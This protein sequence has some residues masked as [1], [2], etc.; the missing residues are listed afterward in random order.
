MQSKKDETKKK[1]ERIST[2]SRIL[3]SGDMIEL[4]FDPL[5]GTTKFAVSVGGDISIVTE[6]RTEAGEFLVPVRGSHGLI[7][8]RVVL[9]PSLA[10]EY[11]SR[12]EL[13]EEVTAYIKRYVNLSPTF[14]TL[15]VHY[16]LLTWVYDVFAEVPYLRF[17]GDFGSGKTRALQVIGAITYK[18]IFASG[19]STVS[20]IFHSLDLFKGTLIF[21][22]ADFRFS[23]ER[24]EVTKI[25][26][27]GTTRGFPVLRASLSEKKDFDPKA[28]D[29]FGPKIVG[30]R[31]VFEDYALESRFFTETM[32]G[33]ARGIPLNLP[34]AQA[35]EALALR[36]K[37]LMFR[38][39]ERHSI[40]L[41]PSVV[42]DRLCARS[43]QLL[44]PLLAIVASE[45][46]REDIK[47]FLRSLEDEQA[48][49]RSTQVEALVLD[50]IL[51]LAAKQPGTT[52]LP[53]SSIREEALKRYAGEFD[54]PLTSRHLGSIIRN[55]LRLKSFKSGVYFVLV[56]SDLELAGLK[57]KYGL[58]LVQ[59]STSGT[60]SSL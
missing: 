40:A 42:D 2:V 52:L 22:E 39:R 49:D 18:P 6:F 37:L 47:D 29:V 5:V 16:V 9:L 44:A 14:L 41:D 51:H 13:L 26:N 55:K 10:S 33:D 23:D 46:V 38:L 20:P 58:T 59:G 11:F 17:K 3:P 1:E 32:T 12:E 56:P 57:A 15:S 45:K 54:R 36:N 53:L 7:R 35:E 31:E 19:A 8:H 28:F 60:Q 21:D 25:F 48:A 50:V 24:A 30:M 34:D 4:I 27:S 43:N